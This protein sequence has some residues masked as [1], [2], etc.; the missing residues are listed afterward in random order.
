MT[1]FGDR[2]EGSGG[3]AKYR[4]TYNRGR[5][6]SLRVGPSGRDRA[7]KLDTASFRIRTAFS[8]ATR[9][10][11]FRFSR[12]PWMFWAAVSGLILLAFAYVVG[13]A[14]WQSAKYPLYGFQDL[15]M[16]YTIDVVIVGWLAWIGSSIGS[17]LNVVAWRMPRGKSVGGRS[18]CPR[19]GSQLLARDQFPVLGWLEVR[20]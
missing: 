18:H 3:D 1:E 15:L 20:M 7:I 11:R 5:Q 10:R 9:R 19:C 12:F 2:H 13:M 16:P 6:Y 8:L 14:A 4:K 17:F